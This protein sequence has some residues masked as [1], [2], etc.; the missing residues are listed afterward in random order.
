M[1]RAALAAL[2]KEGYAVVPRKP[3]KAMR[4]AA[5][6]FGIY[7]ACRDGQNCTNHLFPEEVPE[8]WGAM[9]AALS[10]PPKE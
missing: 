1:A 3:T 9:L 7:R 5:R 6:S 2:E 4:D 10:D 8:V